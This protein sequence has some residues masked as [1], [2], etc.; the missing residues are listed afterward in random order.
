VVRAVMVQHHPGSGRRSRFHRCAPL[1]G[2]FPITPF[3]C[4]CS[5]SQV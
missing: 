4:I 3:H 2:A 1:R 5:L